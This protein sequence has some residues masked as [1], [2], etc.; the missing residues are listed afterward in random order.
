MVT[1]AA[2]HTP[3]LPR[4][5]MELLDVQVGDTVL[6][7]TVGLGGHASLFAEAIGSTGTLVGLDVDPANLA[8]AKEKLSGLSCRV[9]LIQANFATLDDALASVDIAGV[10]VLFADLGVSSTQ[11][12]Q[13]ERGFSFRHD[14][15]LDM[16]LDPSL[17]VTA[18]DLVNR[19]KER[20]LGDLFFYNAQELKSRRI[21]RRICEQRRDGRITTTA[22]LSSIV[23][24]AL[25]SEDSSR[26]TKIH[27]A[28]RVFMALRMAV[29]SEIDR[30]AD[31]LKKAPVVLNPGG[32]F[33]VI[34]FHSVEDKPVK[35]S[36]RDGKKEGVYRIVTKKPVIADANERDRNPRSRSAK[37]RVAIRLSSVNDELSDD[38]TAL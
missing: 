4:E 10:D 30:L 34:A 29:N 13:A 19:L 26:W 8:L 38:L 28:T 24:G 37:L 35:L 7:A 16:R 6:D 33:G 14:G 5:V 17:K 36:F 31:L 11:L 27:P 1:E 25:R 22:R 9:E 32:R 21:A 2:N 12:D 20:E 18:A 23:V 3:V 15:P